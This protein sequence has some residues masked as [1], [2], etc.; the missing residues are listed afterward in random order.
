M[1]N[2]PNCGALINN[3]Q[4]TCSICGGT[5][6]SEVKQEAVIDNNNNNGFVFEQKEEVKNVYEPLQK[7]EVLNVV[8]DNKPSEDDKKNV[9]TNILKEQE[10]KETNKPKKDDSFKAAVLSVIVIII[11]IVGGIVGVK[12]IF[13]L[14]NDGDNHIINSVVT[15]A[16]GYTDIVKR[17]MKKY[18]YK[19]KTTSLNGYYAKS[20]TYN[21]V[22]LPL[23]SK[24]VF[25][26]G[27]WSGADEDEV[28]CAMFFN[29]INNNYCNAVPCDIPSEA[30]IYIKETYETMEINGQEETVTTGTILDGTTLTY[31]DIICSLSNNSYTCEYKE[32]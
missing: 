1:K 20:R 6:A 7:E 5:I 4:T 25:L 16:N 29:D 14:G 10:E 24:C 32:K 13:N 17:Y 19:N 23:T 15:Q 22:S 11:I 21:F 27:K 18:D 3:D 9:M 31:D 8:E 12:Y 26:D 28:T 2:C 30:E